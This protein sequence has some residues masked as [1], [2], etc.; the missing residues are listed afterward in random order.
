M[1]Q[2]QNISHVESE[3]E[4]DHKNIKHREATHRKAQI[5]C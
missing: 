4:R 1:I 2:T 5:Q 3:R